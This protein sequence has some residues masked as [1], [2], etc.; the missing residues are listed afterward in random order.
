MI[1]RISVRPV[2]EGKEG[3]EGML[4]KRERRVFRKR[5][6]GGFAGTSQ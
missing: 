2:I 3:A 5:G 1:A 4:E 6:S